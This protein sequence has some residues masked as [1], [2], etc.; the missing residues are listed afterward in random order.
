MREIHMKR[1]VVVVLGLSLAFVGCPDDIL[2]SQTDTQTAGQDVLEEV[3]GGE[4]TGTDPDVTDEVVVPDVV[5]PDIVESLIGTPC[6][7]PADCPSQQCTD[8][9]TGQA[10]T[11]FC[12]Q[13]DADACPTGWL[14]VQSGTSPAGATFTCEKAQAQLC[15]PCAQDSDCGPADLGDRCVDHGDAGSFCGA[16]CEGGCPTG[17]SC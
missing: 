13:S 10:C 3:A 7:G 14:C 4:V 17:Y 12:D 1:V 2:E 6:T 8:I 11:D 5:D 15:R 9:G 16:R